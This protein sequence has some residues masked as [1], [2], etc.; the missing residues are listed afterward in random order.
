MQLPQDF[1][2]TNTDLHKCVTLNLPN[3]ENLACDPQKRVPFPCN[4]LWFLP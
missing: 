1:L 2:S 4:I 3:F